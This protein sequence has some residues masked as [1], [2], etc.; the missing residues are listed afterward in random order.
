MYL[1]LSIELARRMNESNFA[2]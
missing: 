2:L 1:S